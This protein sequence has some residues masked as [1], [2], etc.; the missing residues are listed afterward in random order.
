MNLDNMNKLIERIRSC[1]WRSETSHPHNKKSF[2]ANMK[3]FHCGSPACVGG[4][5]QDL[6]GRDDIHPKDAIEQ[7]L[8]VHERTAEIL[9]CSL[10]NDTNNEITVAETVAYLEELRD[11]A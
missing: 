5:C 9:F 3:R 10:F 4:H 8:G 6:L 7:F 1:E 2:N 11:Q